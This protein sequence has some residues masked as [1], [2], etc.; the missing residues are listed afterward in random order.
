[1]TTNKKSKLVTSCDIRNKRIKTF[2]N[3]EVKDFAQYVLRSRTMPN[4]MDGLR[5]GARKVIW[6]SLTG[7]LSKK[8]FVKMPALIGDTMKLQYMHGDASLANTIVNLCCTHLNKYAPLEAIGQIPSL[9]VPNCDTATRYLMVKKSEFLDFYTADKELLD[10]Q[11]EEGE[12][13]EPKYFLPIIPLVLLNR[14]SSPGFG[15]SFKSF[16]YRLC[17]VIENTLQAVIN[18]TCVVNKSSVQLTPEVDGIDPSTLIFNSAKNRWYSVGKYE[19]DFAN[20]T[21]II[22]DL[23]FD[24]SFDTLEEQLQKLQENFTIN[25]WI[26]LSEGDKISYVVKFASGRLSTLYNANKWKFFQTF[27]LYSC[28]KQDI[29]NCMDEDGK[30]ILFFESPYHLIDAFVKRRLKFYQARKTRTIKQLEEK[31]ANLE[32]R[33]KFVQHV[34]DGSI[35]VVERK[36]SDIKQQLDKYKIDSYVL[37]MKVYDLTLEK[38]EELNNTLRETVEKLNYIKETTIQE[39]YIED[40]INFKTKYDSIIEKL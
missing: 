1:M 34:I 19:L 7:D 32:M 27:K 30:T 10:I 17:D 11:T 14:T 21:L 40:L 37:D 22:R 35:V 23:P 18:G 5:I 3:T 33:V 13:I 16:S 26:N 28:L 4:I 8:K 9:R 29:L 38:I 31:K 2:M 12:K 6:A 20:N 15:F 25:S 39:M 24:I 36:L